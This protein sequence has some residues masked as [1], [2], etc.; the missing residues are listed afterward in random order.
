MSERAKQ[1][2][3]SF[4]VGLLIVEIPVAYAW[5][6]ATPQ[7]DAR[8]LLA[9]LLG[10]LLTALQRYVQTAPGAVSALHAETQ[11]KIVGRRENQP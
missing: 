7:P 3:L 8:F 2:A 10:G 1:T 9:G 6:V 4:F 11:A 5:L